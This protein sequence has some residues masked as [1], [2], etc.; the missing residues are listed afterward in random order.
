MDDE[1]WFEIE[2]SEMAAM[3]KRDPATVDAFLRL[4]ASVV[5]GIDDPEMEYVDEGVRIAAS[6]PACD[7]PIVVMDA[8]KAVRT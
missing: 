1:I 3:R 5:F 2:R 8:G 4:A 7:A 6:E